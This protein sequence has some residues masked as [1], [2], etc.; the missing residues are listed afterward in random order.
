MGV[1]WKKGSKVETVFQEPIRRNIHT[2]IHALTFQIED[3]AQ[4]VHQ[5]VDNRVTAVRAK[6][7]D[8]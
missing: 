4:N 7:R 1:A 5:F 3:A 6:H 8:N 2:M